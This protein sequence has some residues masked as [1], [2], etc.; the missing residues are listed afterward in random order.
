MNPFQVAIYGMMGG[1]LLGAFTAPDFCVYF[2]LIGA[3]G[4]RASACSRPST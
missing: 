4:S 2:G 1:V 3:G